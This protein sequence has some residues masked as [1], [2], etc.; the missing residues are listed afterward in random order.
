MIQPGLIC[1]T[2]TGS[3]SLGVGQFYLCALDVNVLNVFVLLSN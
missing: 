1:P 3:Y 2:V